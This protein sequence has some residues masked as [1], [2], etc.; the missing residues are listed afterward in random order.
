MY[1]ITPRVKEVD[2]TPPVND[3]LNTCKLP[4]LLNP[5]S[6]TTHISCQVLPIMCLSL[7]HN[8]QILCNQ[9]T[10]PMFYLVFYCILPIK[11]FII[12]IW[13]SAAPLGDTD[14]LLVTTD[15]YMTSIKMDSHLFFP[16]LI[17]LSFM[18][19]NDIQII[20]FCNTLHVLSFILS[21]IIHSINMNIHQGSPLLLWPCSRFRSPHIVSNRSLS[22]YV[23][24]PCLHALVTH[25]HIVYLL[26]NFCHY[27]VSNAQS[28]SYQHYLHVLLNPQFS[29]LSF[30]HS[31]LMLMGLMSPLGLTRSNQTLT[32]SQQ[33]FLSFS[34]SSTDFRGAAAL[35]N[36]AATHMRLYRNQWYR[37]ALKTLFP[38]GAE[39]S[40]GSDHR[41][42][43]PITPTKL[44]KKMAQGY[45]PSSDHW[46]EEFMKRFLVNSPLN[47]VFIPSSMLHNVK[48]L[49]PVGAPLI[50][51]LAVDS[52]RTDSW[53]VGTFGT[54]STIIQEIQE[55]RGLSYQLL[56]MVTV[57]EILVG[58]TSEEECADINAWALDHWTRDQSKCPTK[59]LSFDV[60]EQRIHL[61]DY[62]KLI[63]A[64]DNPVHLDLHFSKG[65]PSKQLPVKWMFGNGMDWA[66]II[67]IIVRPLA[68]KKALIKP[69]NFQRELIRMLENM[70]QLEWVFALMYWRWKSSFVP[71]DF[72]NF[73]WK[74]SLI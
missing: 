71:L 18:G 39:S 45:P 3:L 74:G 54:K 32:I 21:L 9:C 1:L 70:P 64:T 49:L 35:Q 65:D 10:K 42:D 33:K 58:I 27:P 11:R 17:S 40:W 73:V 51:F 14:V 61:S 72:Q 5:T 52:E 15:I 28:V 7:M 68:D 6:N 63:R 30:K 60:E 22:V 20:I 24:S 37:P 19:D 62:H 38:K 8:L 41:N 12:L 43:K 55:T 46:D 25:T 50:D 66:V 13:S 29:S 47:E 69:L 2:V 53:N 59:L 36:A 57:R 34:L 56:D 16:L 44:A 26:T 4:N 48:E 67:S 23:V 31:S